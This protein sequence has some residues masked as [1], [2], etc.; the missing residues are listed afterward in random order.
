MTGEGRGGGEPEDRART[1]RAGERIVE[2]AV[3]REHTER[4]LKRKQDGGRRV[5]WAGGREGG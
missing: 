4:S 3:P 2:K 1:L 5:G